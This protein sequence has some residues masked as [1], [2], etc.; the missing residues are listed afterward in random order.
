MSAAALTLAAALLCPVLAGDNAVGT[1][2][3][4]VNVPG[5]AVA[6]G[7]VVGPTAQPQV[8]VPVQV[9]GPV[10]KSYAFTDKDG[11]WSLYNL[12]AGDY[13]VQPIGTFAVGRGKI[14]SFT[15]RDPGIWTSLA[16]GAQAK[17]YK[18]PD[19]PISKEVD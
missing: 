8:G 19:I 9:Q 2:A 18:A 16:G 13:S 17:T 5:T 3:V 15:V 7:K 1:D 10:G 14:V 11:V 6:T 12:P 4:V